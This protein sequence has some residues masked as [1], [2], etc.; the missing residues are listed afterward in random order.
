MA[1]SN[2]EYQ[3]LLQEYRKLAKKADQRLV[4][5]E[6]LSTEKGFANVKQWAYKRAVQDAMMWGAKET[7]P[8]FNIAP[9]KHLSSL[10]AKIHDIEHF[11]Y[12]TKTSTKKDIMQSFVSKANTINEKYGT[13]LTW[14]DVAT[15]FESTAFKKLDKKF[16]SA[17][18][19]KA[20]GIFQSKSTGEIV[21]DWS[22]SGIERHF[23]TEDN[24]IVVQEAIKQATRYYKKDVRKLLNQ[25]D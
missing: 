15:L 23:K 2:S 16:G 14:S 25:L 12:E 7:K 22:K 18:A 3:A 19:L 5:L 9:P 24:D 1:K 4:R 8:R 13:N 11:L 17:V 6:K 21:I 10:R 20:I